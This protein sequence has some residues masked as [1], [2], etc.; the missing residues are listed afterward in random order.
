[1]WR[2]LCCQCENAFYNIIIIYAIQNIYKLLDIFITFLKSWELNICGKNLVIIISD[3]MLQC[4]Q[5]V[6]EMLS[7]FLMLYDTLLE[8]IS[9]V[10]SPTTTWP[11]KKC[12]SGLH[13]ACSFC[14]VRCPRRGVFLNFRPFHWSLSEIVRPPGIRAMQN[15]LAH[16]HQ[17]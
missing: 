7:C 8:P 16:W 4:I 17:R 12:V 11:C 2:S 1:M 5:Y 9:N 13:W 3:F 15:E 6:G 14:L 10:C